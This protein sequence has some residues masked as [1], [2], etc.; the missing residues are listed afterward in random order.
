MPSRPM[1]RCA[2]GNGVRPHS[3]GTSAFSP[4]SGWAFEHA[5]SRGAASS[6]ASAN[7]A[8][9]A[10]GSTYLSNLPADADLASLAG[11]IKARWFCEQ[12]HQQMKE[13]L[14]LNQ[15]SGSVGSAL[16]RLV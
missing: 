5:G 13:E 11:T 2:L 1:R 6:A 14:G 16:R 10:S 7:T 8:S 9:W 3:H 4:R 15:W 12:A